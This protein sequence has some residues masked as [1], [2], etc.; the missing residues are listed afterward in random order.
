MNSTLPQRTRTYQNHHLDSTRWDNFKVRD[1][2]ILV[3]TS[4][5]SG[6]T[7]MQRIVAL[8][9]F[10]DQQPEQSFHDI[11]VWLDIRLPP[12]GP[13]MEAIEAQTHRRFLKTHSA[14]DGIPY[15]PEMKYL[16]IGRDVRD[17]FMS[18][19]NHASNY[20]DEFMEMLNSAPDRVG[21]P[22]S[23]PY[24]NIHELWHDWINKGNFEWETDGYPFWSHLHFVQSWW[25]YRH[26]PNIYLVHFND[27]LKDLEG[28]MR[29]VAEF[30]N[31]KVEESLWPSLVEQATFE[32]M[33]NNAAELL[34]G[35]DGIFAGGAKS[36]INKGTNGRWRDILSP[37]EL[38]E[39][40][41][42][43]ARELSPDCALWLEE[44]GAENL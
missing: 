16:V 23:L 37:E 33:K 17:V 22:L 27:L 36:F 39:C 4:M 35:I 6:T 1:D 12:L 28:E 38:I 21:E 18:L 44:G 2:D 24:E 9:L 13:T 5:K 3:C 29:K 11:S 30:L 8:L 10:Q 20:T 25:E 32:N 19:W 26:M 34:P 15:F 42:A 40:D 43:I 31:I 41:A 14:L 7:W